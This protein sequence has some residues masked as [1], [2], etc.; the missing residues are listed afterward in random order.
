MKN[1]KKTLFYTIIDHLL[2]EN[3]LKN[4][5]DIDFRREIWIKFYLKGYLSSIQVVLQ[6][7]LKTGERKYKLAV[8]THSKVIVTAL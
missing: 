1:H 4:T 7:L 5:T 8:G 2:Y 6:W 3:L